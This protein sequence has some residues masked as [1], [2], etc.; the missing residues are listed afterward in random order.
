LE[1]GRSG[2]KIIAEQT[3]PNGFQDGFPRGEQN[4]L[5]RSNIEVGE[6]KSVFEI[7]E[8]MV[9][10]R[11]EIPEG[12]PEILEKTINKDPR[13]IECSVSLAGGPMTASDLCDITVDLP[14]E[15]PEET[16]GK[17]ESLPQNLRRNQ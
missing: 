1:K 10:I 5:R 6:G 16:S 2:G 3:T 8:V 15:G 4:M 17:P 13:N 14:S 12:E 9:S 7:Q 11:S